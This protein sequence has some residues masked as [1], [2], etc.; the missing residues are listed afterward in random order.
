MDD[1]R[2]RLL[3][4]LLFCPAST[5]GT[6]IHEIVGEN[7]GELIG[8]AAEVSRPTLRFQRQNHARDGIRSGCLSREH[9]KREEERC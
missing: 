2:S 5:T 6:N 9:N 4:I 3:H 8:V 1:M 7:T